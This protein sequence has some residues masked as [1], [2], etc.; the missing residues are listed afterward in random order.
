MERKE[1]IKQLN[2]E[3]LVRHNK[4]IARAENNLAQA[5]QNQEFAQ[6]LQRQKVLEFEIAKLKFENKDASIKETE[7]AK[8]KEDQTKILKKLHISPASLVPQYQ[9]KK[10]NDTGYA[11]GKQCTCFKT[12]LNRHLIALSGLE[13]TTLTTFKNFDSR[14][15]KDK[16][17]QET[18]EKLKNLLL[19]Y[20]NKFPYTPYS[21]IL[22][23]G[24]TGV[25]KTFA[26][27]CTASEVIKRGYTANFITAFQLNNQFLKYH[28]CF[29]ANKQ[30][31]M[32]MLLLPD[33]LVIDDLGTEP[34]L[35]NVT[36]EYLLAVIQERMLKHKATLISTNLSPEQIFDRY[37][38]R[39]FSRI[40][41]KGK[42]LLINIEGNDLRQG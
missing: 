30:S 12:E 41:H 5:S 1:L 4:A 8:C 23:A 32:D 19:Q 24:H 18:L 16:K 14:I 38:E 36:K 29:D 21:I 39:L 34:V 2:D 37:G 31:Y 20:C 15:A 3:F 35:R 40:T 10:C 26:L 27:E 6:N 11:G 25:G 7:L 42:S 13:P 22:L 17:Q 9:C 28:T 33:L